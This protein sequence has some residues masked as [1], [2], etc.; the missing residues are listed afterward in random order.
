M[1]ALREGNF[2]IWLDGC[3][4]VLLGTDKST[5]TFINH[6]ERKSVQINYFAEEN[7]QNTKN[8]G[9]S[10]KRFGGTGGSGS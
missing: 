7:C 6:R 8:R 3:L 5:N 2:L 1:H 10:K 9:G 4:L